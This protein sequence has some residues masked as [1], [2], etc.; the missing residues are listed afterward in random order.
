M[1]I[2][3]TLPNAVHDMLAVMDAIDA[4]IQKSKML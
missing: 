1:T 2:F 4:C 3:T